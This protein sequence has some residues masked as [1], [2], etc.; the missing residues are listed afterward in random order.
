LGNPGVWLSG[1][2]DTWILGYPGTLVFGWLGS[3]VTLVHGDPNNG[4]FG[5]Y[6]DGDSMTQQ[7]G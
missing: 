7:P 5:R 2:L 4:A 6:G 3:W 1:Y